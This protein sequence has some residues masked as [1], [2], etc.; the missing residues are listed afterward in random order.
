MI[1]LKQSQ[2]RYSDVTPKEV[3][4]NRRRFL[5]ASA[6]AIGGMAAP[7]SAA[8]APTKLNAIKAPAQFNVTDKETPLA[9][10]AGYN[11]F[12]EF[13]TGKEE[14]SHNAPKWHVPA[15]WSVRIEG[16]GAN[17]PQTLDLTAIMKL[18]PLEERIYR[19]R[20]VEAWSIV[21]PWIGFSLNDVAQAGSSQR[22]SQVR[23]VQSYYDSKSMLSSG[24]A[25]IRFP[26]VEGLRMDE[27]MHPLAMLVVGLYGETLPQ[28]ERRA[29]AAG[30]AVEVRIQEHQVASTKSAWWRRKP[31]TTWNISNAQRVR[32]LFECEP[33]S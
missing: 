21:V 31:P 17:K 25:G 2:L 20:C 8:A 5:V 4:V 30:G 28:P 23:C 10:V 9:T 26:Y 15:P 12:Y 27:A 18:A 6:A 33:A 22:Q 13:G 1:I 24:A 16:T 11:N 7:H 29:L 32:F 14:P 19:H 3:Y